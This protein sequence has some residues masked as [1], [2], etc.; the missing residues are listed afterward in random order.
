MGKV[1]MGAVVS[2]DGFVAAEDDGVGPLF[3]WYGNGDV[4]V[5]LG[6]PD[7]VFRVSAASAAYIRSEWSGVRA[8]VIGRRLFDITNGW[9]GVPAAGEHVFVVTHQVPADWPYP[10][11]PFTFVTD[12]V[13]SAIAQAQAFAGDGDVSVTAGDVG[14]QALALGLVDEVHSDLVPVVFGSGKRFYGSFTGGPQL[15]EDPRVVVEGD[16]VLHLVH[17]VRR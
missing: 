16:R 15:L 10:D 12:G 5:T 17:P 14:G 6:D 9:G 4:E 3:D 7:R 1:L 13:A 11:A 8:T 2:L